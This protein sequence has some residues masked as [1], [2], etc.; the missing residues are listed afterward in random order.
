M[1]TILGW[2]AY[3]ACSWTWCIGMFLPVLL[4][5][6]Y[7]VWGFVVFAVPNVLGAAAMG[8]VLGRS[9]DAERILAGHGAALRAFSIV[10]CVFHGAWM[11]WVLASLL[12]VEGAARALGVPIAVVVSALAWRP[13]GARR[14]GAAVWLVSILAGAALWRSGAFEVSAGFLRDAG[15]RPT[16][17][18]SL[19]WLA[20]VCAFGFGLC[21]YLD[22]TFLRARSSLDRAGARGAFTLGFGVLFVPMILLTLGYTAPLMLGQDF[23][24]SSGVFVAAALLHMWV[25][26]CY[27]CVLHLSEATGLFRRGTLVWVLAVA[28][29]AVGV[30]V[31]GTP[32]P[33]AASLDAEGMSLGEIV[34]RVFMSFY[35][36]VFPAYVWLLMIPTRDGHS[37][38]GG[39]QGRR[40]MVVWGVAVALAA[41]CLWMGFIERE[42][43]WLGPGLVIV[44]V[45]R[46]LLPR[47]VTWV[48]A[49]A[50][51]ASGAPP[52]GGNAASSRG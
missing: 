46:L 48:T 12:P 26:S 24:R 16:D 40:K 20:P 28:A 50:P 11:I 9:G 51:A 38:P 14:W 35:G 4:V 17:P 33:G 37:G 32:R 21:P 31:L 36:L 42:E 1:W 19:V 23:H 41:P 7:G 49:G 2:A 30:I 13:V 3:L 5:R 47:G 34:Y 25:Q 10:T 44:L 45:A 52:I 29:A 22:R 18:A 43:A 6:D 8:W 15:A 27:T 39:E